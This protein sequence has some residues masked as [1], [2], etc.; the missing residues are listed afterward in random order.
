[1]GVGVAG[2]VCLGFCRE[3]VS[4]EEAMLGAIADVKAVIRG[5]SLVAAKLESA[6]GTRIGIAAGAFDIPDDLDVNNAEVAALLYGEWRVNLEQASSRRSGG[7]E[8]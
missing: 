3:A 6:T 5:S 2:Y 4:A 7:A 1:M 8:G